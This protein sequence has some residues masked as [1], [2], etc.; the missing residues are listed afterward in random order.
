MLTRID[1]QYFGTMAGVRGFKDP[2]VVISSNTK[3]DAFHQQVDS[4]V[5]PAPPA[6][7]TVLQ[8][9]WINA[10]GGDSLDRYQCMLAGSNGWQ[11]NHA[12]WNKGNVD[13]W[14]INN[15]GEIVLT[16]TKIFHH[17]ALLTSRLH[18]L[19]ARILHEKGLA[20]P[21]RLGRCLHRWRCLP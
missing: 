3:Q 13:R 9:W 16:F 19:L 12:A 1:A 15:T 5:E 17:S 8:P 20:L 4:T 6:G 18:S 21:L 10:A 14:A 7:V 11:E 2:N